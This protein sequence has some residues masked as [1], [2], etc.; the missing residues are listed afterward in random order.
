MQQLGEVASQ[1]LSITRFLGFLLSFSLLL[2]W[3]L[4]KSV[5]IMSH[6]VWMSWE[7]PTLPTKGKTHR[8]RDFG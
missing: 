4:V 8:G 5:G 6:C 1:T 2:K 7:M 3:D